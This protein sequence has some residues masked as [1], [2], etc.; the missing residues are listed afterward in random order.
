[1]TTATYPSTNAWSTENYPTMFTV[2][3][4]IN[5]VRLY[6]WIEGQDVDC[7][8]S[9]SLGSAVGVTINLNAKQ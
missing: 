8:N 5:K 7:E 3:Q 4:G 6:I 2:H 1:M 9:A